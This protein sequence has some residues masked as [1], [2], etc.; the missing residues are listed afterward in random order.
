MRRERGSKIVR[1]K[2]LLAVLNSFKGSRRLQFELFTRHGK[3]IGL[4][5]TSLLLLGEMQKSRDITLVRLKAS[6][7]FTLGPLT[8]DKG[9]KDPTP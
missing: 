1:K 6:R 9:D 8:A 3:D 4:W 2:N 5:K 7:H